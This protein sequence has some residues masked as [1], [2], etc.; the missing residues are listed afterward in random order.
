MIMM[1]SAVICSEEKTMAIWNLLEWPARLSYEIIVYES[2]LSPR[3]SAA[4]GRIIVN[5]A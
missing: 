2:I 5:L 1:P 3:A 4:V